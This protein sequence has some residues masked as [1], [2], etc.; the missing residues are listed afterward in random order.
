MGYLHLAVQCKHTH[1]Q[2]D[3]HTHTHTHAHTYTH[4]RLGS[5]LQTHLEPNL[6][7]HLLTK[8]Q[9]NF[10]FHNFHIQRRST[11]RLTSSSTSIIRH[12]LVH[13]RTIPDQEEEELEVHP[14]SSAALHSELTFGLNSH[15]PSPSAI[16]STPKPSPHPSI[17]IPSQLSSTPKLLS[18]QQS[19]PSQFSHTP[20][21][22]PTA[23][24]LASHVFSSGAEAGALP[25]SAQHRMS[26]TS[27]GEHVLLFRSHG[28]FAE[29]GSL[30]LS[31]TM[32]GACKSNGL[33]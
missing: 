32:R 7:A 30:G 9:G 19:T 15:T 18:P 6:E 16:G 24:G 27:A 10:N 25:F 1:T 28:Y 13:A 22:T 23:L 29:A 21:P 5:P 8:E 4:A 3:T 26:P 14:E 12:L 2:T 20:A 17:Y 33:Q 31:C 11:A